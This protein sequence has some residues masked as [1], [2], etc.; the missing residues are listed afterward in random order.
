MTIARRSAAVTNQTG[1]QTEIRSIDIEGQVLR[2]G[3][4][5]GPGTPLLI[6]NGIGAS[7]ELL[8]PFVRELPDM[9]VILF[10]VPGVGKSA[11]PS[12]PYRFSGLARLADKM[13]TALGYHDQVDVLGV[14]WGGAVAQ[15][16]AW[17]CSK[18]CRRLVL[19]ATTPG[20]VMVPGRVWLLRSLLSR[21]RH[22]DPDYMARIAPDLYGGAFRRDPKLMKN[23]AAHLKPPKLLGYFYQQLAFLGWT[24]MRWLFLLR[25]P[26][27]VLS[28]KDDPLVP[29]MNGRILS[30]MIPGAQ[31]R[32][33]DDGHLFLITSRNKVAPLVRKFLRAR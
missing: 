1:P 23:L 2:V 21:R 14:S 5:R 10:D 25:Q 13:L 33:F 8:E 30:F 4:R 31:L 7:F 16:F 19:A 17:T 9:E 6:F 3:I 29:A 32:L 28:G 22:R 26:T 24:S 18:R 12:L 20:V 15:Q 27:L 11:S